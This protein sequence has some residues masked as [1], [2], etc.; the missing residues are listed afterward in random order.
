M[1][2]LETAA[3]LCPT[4]A[5]VHFQLATAIGAKMDCEKRLISEGNG[6]TDITWSAGAD[7][8]KVAAALER[9]AQLESAAV[10]AGVNGIEDL[11]ICLN[12]LAQTRCELGEY[13]KAL[14]AMD[15]WAECG[16]IRSALAVEDNAIQLGEIPNHEW[17]QSPGSDGKGR[18]VAVR[19]VGDTPLFQ[20]EDIDLLRSAADRRFA[21]AAGIQ[22]SRYTMQYEGML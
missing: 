21:L 9:S 14:D 18:N 12:A 3:T 20:P 2:H 16:S 5:R 6:E 11:S 13:D 17:I 15:R 1:F 4:D 22:T 7:R 10:K 19:T 8:A